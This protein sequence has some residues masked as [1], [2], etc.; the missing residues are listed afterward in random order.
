MAGQKGRD[1]LLKISD[2]GGGYVTLAGIRASRI[3]LSAAL[4]DATSADSPE[5][6][7][8]LL[9]GAGA[10]TAKV[11]G[12]GVFKDAASDARMR[13]VFFAGEA[14]DWQFI[15]PDFGTLAG[16]FQVSE[17]SWSGEYD[18]EAEFSVTLESAGLV[19]FEAMP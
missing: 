1:I 18:G 7:R 4:V 11:T 6:W 12:R 13:A 16:A 5:A 2:G 14:P 3:Q 19:S 9:A 15:L 10:K 8:E 17:L